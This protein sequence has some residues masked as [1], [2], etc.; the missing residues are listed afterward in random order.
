MKKNND[1]TVRLFFKLLRFGLWG[2]SEDVSEAER[3]SESIVPEGGEIKALNLTEDLD[4]KQLYRLACEQ[5][6]AG[7]VAVGLEQY[8]AEMKQNQSDRIDNDVSDNNVEEVS[9]GSHKPKMKNEKINASRPTAPENVIQAFKKIKFSIG[10]SNYRMNNF[11]ANLIKELEEV[12]IEPLLLKGQGV[13]QNYL[14]PEVRQ[15]GDIDLLLHGE[16]YEKAKMFLTPKADNLEIEENRRKH[17]GMHIGYFEVELHGTIHCNFGNKINTYLDKKQDELFIKKNFRYWCYKDV[18]ISMP[19]AD[20]DALFIFTH[21]L[22][23]FYFGGLG[24]R[25][26]CD[27]IMFLHKSVQHIDSAELENDIKKLGVLREWQTFG[28]FAVKYLGMPEEEMPMYNNKY[29]KKADKIRDFLIASGNFGKNRG[30][31]DY[32]KDCYII[33]KAKSLF[34]KGGYIINFLPVFPGNTIRFFFTFLSTG[35]SSAAKGE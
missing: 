5:T 12:G 20:F 28:C 22:N 11:L 23:H 21:F 33:R 18:E 4:W 16:D 25:Q 29:T 31:R 24:L 27:W 1:N 14:Y 17:L 13:A 8:V 19:S 30:Y 3:K 15:A 35:F 26:I 34:I 7:Y 32:S 9:F 6:V 2:S 10:L